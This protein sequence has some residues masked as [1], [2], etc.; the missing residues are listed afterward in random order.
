MILNLVQFFFQSFKDIEFLSYIFAVVHD[1]LCKTHFT[2]LSF[3]NID[4]YM[5]NII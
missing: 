5:Y 3:V 2:I 4:I 1:L